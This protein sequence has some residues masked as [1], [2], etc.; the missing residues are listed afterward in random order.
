V[1]SRA[2]AAPGS[3]T[4]AA[5]LIAALEAMPRP[6]L[7]L[8]AWGLLVGVLGGLALFASSPSEWPIQGSRS[9]GLRDSLAM[10]NHGGPLLLGRHGGVGPL[11][12]VGA[13]DDLG[14]YVYLPWLSHALGI[15][16]PVK[17]LRYGFAV[18]FGGTAVFYP[19]VFWRLT[20]SLLAAF[21]A[22]VALL[23]CVRSLGFS[24]IYWLPAWAS[25]TLL[26][27][28]MVLSERRGR[29]AWTGLVA[30][31]LAAGWLNT[32]RSESG[33]GVLV[34][35]VIVL[36][37]QRLRWWRTLVVFAT[38]VLAY[39]SIGTFAIAAIRDHRDHRVGVA[40]SSGHPQSH[41]FW[42]PMYLG[43]GYLPNNYG[44]RFLD[45]I[46]AARVQHDAPGTV[47]LS[48]R[49]ESTLRKAYFGIVR[50][51]PL[52]VLGQYAAKAWVTLADTAPYLLLIALT[53]PALRSL[54]LR[55][56]VKRWLPLIAPSLI[57]M[58][59]PT[60]VAIPLQIY[61]E[62]LYGTV[63]LI[64]ILGITV[65]IAELSRAARSAGALRPAL[66]TLLGTH[67]A[68]SRP[69]P[70]SRR[71]ITATVLAVALI[72]LVV[73]AHFIRRDAEAW[74]HLSSGVL[75]DRAP[76]QTTAA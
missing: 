47:Y 63:G 42:H 74:Q 73:S 24:D 59:L 72:A 29:R 17:L 40:L 71:A 1:S 3:P 15:G 69:I 67:S 51:H 18:L 76:T 50:A 55:S 21:A 28:L 9:S 45:Q 13:T 70:A 49:Y 31:A 10:L 19:L 22:P 6:R 68:I 60:L 12:P 39:I 37:M 34:A 20:G 58:F 11:Y 14:I 32:M 35:A 75:I 26:P 57:V 61:E 16:D 52:E 41:P 62:G 56:R 25:V 65:T 4:A 23:F 43:L 27:P 5:R 54:S 46:A 44:I 30:I 64:A 66:P 2:A 38:M 48:N 7:T 8:I 53:L 36:A 33:L